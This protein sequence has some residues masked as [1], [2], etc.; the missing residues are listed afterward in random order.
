M[1]W[2][3]SVE[4]RFG[5]TEEELKGMITSSKELPGKITELESKMAT[6]EDFEKVSN[7]LASI[8]AH[9]EKAAKPVEPVVNNNGGGE[10]NEPPDWSTDPDGAF[11]AGMRPVAG[12]ALTA[13]AFAVRT[14]VFSDTEKYKYYP[15]LKKEIDEYI[16]KQ[17]LN[18]QINPEVIENCYKVIL[19][20]NMDKIIQDTEKKEGRFYLE[21]GSSRTNTE[22]VDK[23]K[24]PAEKQLSAKELEVCKK[25]KITPADYLV[26]KN[27][28]V[29]V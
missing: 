8:N 2:N 9:L 4:E 6:K 3:K 21:S 19:A 16:K 18:M 12:V 24:L 10:G 26:E 1:V 23:T 14:D 22:I 27:K 11:K 25:M 29:V 7:T 20:E 15:A 17:S 13:Q 28:M 5:M